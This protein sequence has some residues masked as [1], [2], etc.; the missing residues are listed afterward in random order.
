MD[1]QDRIWAVIDNGTVTNIVVWDGTVYDAETNPSGWTPPEGATLIEVFGD[2]YDGADIGGT[3][4]G[5]TFAPNLN[6]PEPTPEPPPL[7]DNIQELAQILFDK[8]VLTV[9][10][11]TP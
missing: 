7:P 5:T 9:A 1:E 4:N 6:I 3:Y 11:L 10:D 2:D 8:G